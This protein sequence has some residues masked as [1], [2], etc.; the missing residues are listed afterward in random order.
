M[1]VQYKVL[2]PPD[3]L[4]RDSNRLPGI[5]THTESISSPWGECRRSTAQPEAH[6]Y[7]F[8]HRRVPPGTHLY[9]WV[10]RSTHRVRI[11]PRDFHMA[12]SGIEPRSSRSKSDTQLL[13]HDLGF[14][15]RLYSRLFP[16]LLGLIT[17]APSFSVFFLSLAPGG[18]LWSLQ[19]L[20]RTHIDNFDCLFPTRYPSQL[21]RLMWLRPKRDSNPWPWRNVDGI[22]NHYSHC[23]IP[24]HIWTNGKRVF[25]KW[26]N[27]NLLRLR[28]V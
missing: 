28:I 13:C 8:V 2:E 23:T 21:G 6:S 25:E 7:I 16:W 1:S 18:L 11:L 3:F 10:D 14:L 15:M 22:S 20:E 24:P 26:R 9:C 27:D 4:R 17:P 5:G 19:P 12:Q